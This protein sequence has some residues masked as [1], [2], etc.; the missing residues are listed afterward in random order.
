[1]LLIYNT[2]IKIYHFLIWITS[3]FNIKAKKWIS[4]RENWVF[5]LENLNTNK[6]K[7]WFHFASLGEFEQG[8]PVLE[9]IKAKFPDKFIVITFFSPSGY[10]IKK[11]STLG[12]LIMY[13]P[14]DTAG[15]AHKFVSKVNPEM[16]I[17][18][19][20]EFWYHYF[21]E[22]NKRE[23][24]I[25]LISAIFRPRQIY[26]KFYG[27]F[28]RK[29][30]KCVSY[31]FVQNAESI[32]LLK[33]IGLNNALV[34]GDTR[35]DTVS[36]NTKNIKKF[37]IIETFCCNQKVFIAGSTWP[38]DEE[39][40]AQLII[41]NP[42]RKF[43]IAPHEISEQKLNILQKLIPNKSARYSQMLEPETSTNT[44]FKSLQVIIID[45]IGMLSSLYQYGN[46]AYIGGGFG[47]GIHNTLEAAAFG[48]PVIF[49]PNYQKFQEAKDLIRNGGGFSINSSADLLS[50]FKKLYN[51]NLL[52]LK[53]S[54]QTKNYV[55]QNIGA[56]N[57]I[58]KKMFE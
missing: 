5:N 29:I 36:A 27:G 14:L 44:D 58:I 41:K 3:F 54:Q 55:N 22:L 37:P 26:F 40:I 6:A 43:I 31:F 51:D 11:N 7:I 56:T 53:A 9:A 48:L 2:G 34:T 1:M 15:N 4:G 47:A 45:N 39:I 49:G 10:E 20:Y 46:L 17:F 33:K 38:H 32:L 50:I 42:D 19:K 28:Y 35:F 13:L 23:I 52:M 8:K 21:K 57:L 12:N 25:F 16:V 18:T 24:P 30:L